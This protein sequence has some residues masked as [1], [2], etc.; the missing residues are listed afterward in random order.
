MFRKHF[1]SAYD[2]YVDHCRKHSANPAGLLGSTYLI[3]SDSGD[4][5]NF[6]KPLA[7]YV[8]C[9]FT[10]DAFGRRKDVPDDILENTRQSME[11]LD[12]Q[13]A[14]LVDQGESIEQKDGVCVVNMPKIN[15][16][17]FSVPWEETAAVL[18]GENASSVKDNFH[19]KRSHINVY[20]L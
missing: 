10:S 17:L 12:K 15:A 18:E 3:K 13:L 16:G 7:A 11:D 2:R 8:A 9:M 19:E 4:P 20:V 5:G 6:E 14:S 1:P